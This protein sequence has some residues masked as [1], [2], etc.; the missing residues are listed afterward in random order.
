[1]FSGTTPV[2]KSSELVSPSFDEDV[3]TRGETICGNDALVLD[4]EGEELLVQAIAVR[5]KGL[6]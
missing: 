2:D 1:M 4:D 3:D 5:T 6:L